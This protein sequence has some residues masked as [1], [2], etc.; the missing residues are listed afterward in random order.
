MNLRRNI[1]YTIITILAFASASA[2]IAVWDVMPKYEKLNRYYGN[3]YAFQQNGKWGLVQGGSKEI[4]SAS[5]DFITPFTNGYALAGIKDGTRYLLEY[6]IDEDGTVTTLSDKYYLPAS[7]QY[8]SDGKLAVVNKNGKYGYISTDGHTIVK[9]QFDNALPFKEGWAPVKQGNYTKYISD[10]YDKNQ[11]RSILTV[12]FHYGEMTLASCFFNGK[13]VVAYNKDFAIISKNG[14]KVKKI[15]ETEFKQLYKKNNAQVSTSNNGFNEISRYEIITQNGKCGLKEGGEV[16]LIPQFDSFPT[17]FSDG[18]VLAVMNGNYGVLKIVDGSITSSV[19][20][21]EID[22]DRKGNIA[23]IS[24]NYTIPASLSNIKILLDLG[25]GVYKDF[26]SQLS[27]N[28]N[29]SSLAVTPIVPK[30]ADSCVIKGIVENDGIIMADFEK[31]IVLN[32]PIK[33]RVSAP[34]PST[35]RANENDMA[36]VRSTIF[37]DSNKQVNVTATWSTGKTVTITI[38]AHGSK[39]IS[40]S[41]HVSSN[42]AKEISLMLSTGERSRATINFQTFF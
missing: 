36:S 14:Q 18:V 11:S 6:I 13:A 28:G 23:P 12:D 9:C 31:Y 3:I 2:K 15:N 7:N 39:T 17:Q 24:I 42:F 19:L 38:P 30:N 1:L 41:I 16:V 40:D 10:N 5:C 33:L 25:D 27:Y 37:N 29:N 26:Y 32:Y 21:S 20:S 8:V 4:I 22:V 34:G 35:I